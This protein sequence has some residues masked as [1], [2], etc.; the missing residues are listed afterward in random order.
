MNPSII[1]LEWEAFSYEISEIANGK[2]LDC[3]FFILEN[4]S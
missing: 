1:E 3:C 4:Y 2:Y